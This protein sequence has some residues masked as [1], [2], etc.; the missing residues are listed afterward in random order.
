MLFVPVPICQHGLSEPGSSMIRIHSLRFQEAVICQF[1]II[2][3]EVQVSKV[4]PYNRILLISSTPDS[5]LIEQNVPFD[6]VQERL[7][8]R[9]EPAVHL[10]LRKAHRGRSIAFHLLHPVP[11]RVE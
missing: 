4:R 8:K 6:T 3:S 10:P 9:V 1:T 7:Q 11:A 5:L 2:K